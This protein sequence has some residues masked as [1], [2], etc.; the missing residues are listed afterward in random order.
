MPIVTK[1]S[2]GNTITID[3]EEYNTLLHIA[4]VTSEYI[5]GKDK[6]FDS[7]EALISHLKSL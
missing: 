3:K 5:E 2:T 6:S 4:Q 1:Q 7:S